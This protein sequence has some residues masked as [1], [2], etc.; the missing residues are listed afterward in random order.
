M[1]E[2]LQRRVEARRQAV[3]LALEH[4]DPTEE[5]LDKL[6]GTSTVEA[7]LRDAATWLV[8]QGRHASLRAVSQAMDRSAWL[9]PLEPSFLWMTLA[10]ARDRRTAAQYT[11][12]ICMAGLVQAWCLT[13]TD[14]A[15][16]LREYAC[17]AG[18][19][20]PPSLRRLLLSR[21]ANGGMQRVWHICLPTFI[22]NNQASLLE[23][24]REC[25]LLHDDVDAELRQELTH[26]FDTLCLHWRHTGP[27]G[28]QRLW[29]SMR[30]ALALFQPHPASQMWWRGAAVAAPLRL[31]VDDFPT[32]APNSRT[33]WSSVR[34]IT[35]EKLDI[36]IFGAGMFS[37]AETLNQLRI[38]LLDSFAFWCNSR[39]EWAAMAWMAAN[40]F[41]V[42]T[43]AQQE[44]TIQGLQALDCLSSS[45]PTLVAMQAV[46]S[47]TPRQPLL[48]LLAGRNTGRI[49]SL[50]YPRRR[51]AC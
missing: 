8:Q 38:D 9:P 2:T 37:T 1:E 47:A 33:P 31:V 29:R 26:A 25:G 32:S 40:L 12:T 28:K 27:G 34:P 48:R 51:A 46:R 42:L 21:S 4:G 18:G 19:V 49:V 41:E 39:L 22:S 44:D 3:V 24:S 43:Q 7:L 20:I 23:L 30:V 36:L 15:T 11:G 13:A 5:L 50:A 45:R 16:F 35:V 6:A 10:H 14:L 17:M